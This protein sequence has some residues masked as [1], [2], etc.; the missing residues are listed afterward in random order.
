MT[1]EGRTALSVEICTKRCGARPSAAASTTLRVP[2]TLVL[3]RLDRMVLE[4]GHVLVGGGV[5]HD[6]GAV[7]L[8]GLEARRRGR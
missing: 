4:H 7:A 2:K 8:E 3:D 6:L 1:L 5:E